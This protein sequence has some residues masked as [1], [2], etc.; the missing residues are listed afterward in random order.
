MVIQSAGFVILHVADTDSR[1]ASY[2]EARAAFIDDNE[3]FTWGKVRVET[4]N[5][6]PIVYVS[7]TFAYISMP[8]KTSKDIVYIYLFKLLYMQNFEQ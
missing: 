5:E 3:R 1:T 6:L 2:H 4:T 8:Y 7:K